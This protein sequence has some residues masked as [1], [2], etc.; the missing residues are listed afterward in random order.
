MT[1]R[2]DTKKRKKNTGEPGNPGQFGSLN[3]AEA[4]ATLSRIPARFTPL[5]PDG[6]TRLEIATDDIEIVSGEPF[7]SS[8]GIQGRI[9]VKGELFDVEGKPCGL[10]CY[11]DATL[12]KVPDEGLSVKNS[13]RSFR[14]DGAPGTRDIYS[15]FS[16][17]SKQCDQETF[18][19]ID[20]R[21]SVEPD[22]LYVLDDGGSEQ[23]IVDSPAGERRIY[24][25]EKTALRARAAG[26]WDANHPD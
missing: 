5:G 18:A 15:T 12:V 14:E 6:K 19:E 22:V 26:K 16:L 24:D 4:T 13:Y 9:R 20:R 8:R 3:R 7:V 21:G 1:N 2:Q 23:F 10:R 25:D 11:C 17:R